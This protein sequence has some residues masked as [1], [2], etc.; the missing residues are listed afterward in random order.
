MLPGYITQAEQVK[1]SDVV[2][3][4]ILGNNQRQGLTFTPLSVERH[5]Y[6][7]TVLSLI[8]GQVNKF[9]LP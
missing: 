8:L 1:K 5:H 4:H 2:Y 7:G 9:Q 3:K 6:Y